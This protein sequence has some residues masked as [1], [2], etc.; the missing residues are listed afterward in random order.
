VRG[1]VG[2]QRG[3]RGVTTLPGVA[4]DVV[5]P[6]RSRDE[7][8]IGHDPVEPAPVHRVQ[9]RPGQQLD[10]QLVERE[11]GPGHGQR[12][13]RE[14]GS[15]HSR[16]E[17]GGV[18]G[19]HPAAG[20]QVEQRCRRPSHGG[21]GQRERRRPDPG[22]VVAL[23]A[24][25]VEVRQH[26]PVGALLAVGAQVEFG[27][28]AGVDPAQQPGGRGVRGR[29]RSQRGGHRRIR[30]DG[31]EQQQP[32]QHAQLTAVPAGPRGGL[33]LAPT[34]RR[35]CSRPEQVPDAVRGVAVAAQAVPQCGGGVGTEEG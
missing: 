25:G 21:R 23:L 35:V 16:G 27:R 29:E 31:A 2:Q 19:L 11:G 15:G 17:P 7:R 18:Q 34:E 28:P 5:H 10:V 12:A 22:H 1:Q 14:V 30:F 8:R 9:P 6:R 32:N 13:R 26:P 33:G 3:Q 24:A 4:V 20:A